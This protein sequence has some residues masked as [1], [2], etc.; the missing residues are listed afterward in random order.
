M[1]VQGVLERL[2]WF[3]TTPPLLFSG[4]VMTSFPSE[5]PEETETTTKR[6]IRITPFERVRQ[7]PDDF[8]VRNNASE[9]WCIS[10]GVHVHH[11]EKCTAEKHLQSQTH[12]KM[13]RF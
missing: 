6:G 9:M 4:F 11:E 13:R 8:E 1:H 3:C 12:K 2:H 5:S 10:C 7:Y